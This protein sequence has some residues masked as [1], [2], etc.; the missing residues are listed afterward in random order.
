M[1]RRVVTRQSGSSG[2]R[3]GEGPTRAWA[4][5]PPPETQVA[6]YRTALDQTGQG[7]CFFGGDR[8]LILSNRRYERIYGLAADS[9]RPG[10][11]LAEIVEMRF[12][13][14]ES[15]WAT[16]QE[17]RAWRDKM[18]C[19]AEA[20]TFTAGLRNGRTIRILNQP[21]PDGGWVAVHEEVTERVRLEGQLQS[22]LASLLEEQARR[23]KAE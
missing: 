3:P 7:V 22:T 11:T 17:Y 16:Q 14:G 20:Q 5:R 2:G 13:R 10:M 23:A 19:G 1:P 4:T 21:T 15:P 18:N 6:H 12:A 9:V 8:R